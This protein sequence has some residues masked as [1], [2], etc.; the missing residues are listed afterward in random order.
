MCDVDQPLLYLS[1]PLNLLLDKTNIQN[2]HTTY[3]I[4]GKNMLEM[5][6]F[7]LKYFMP[8]VKCKISE[9]M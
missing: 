7:I 6:T 9:F 5:N 3:T 8:Y 4:Q 2:A 1:K